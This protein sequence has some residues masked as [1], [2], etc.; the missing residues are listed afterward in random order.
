MCVADLFSSVDKIL[1]CNSRG[2]MEFTEKN[3]SDFSS[4]ATKNFTD[5]SAKD[6]KEHKKN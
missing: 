6:A 1:N 2:K 4:Q 5:S 3:D